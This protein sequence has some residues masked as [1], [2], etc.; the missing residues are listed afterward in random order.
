MIRFSS[1]VPLSVEPSSATRISYLKQEDDSGEEERV[2]EEE[3]NN[4]A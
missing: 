4:E 3:D 2:S 1:T